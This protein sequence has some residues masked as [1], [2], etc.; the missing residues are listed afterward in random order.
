MMPLGGAGT[1]IRGFL[2]EAAVLCCLVSCARVAAQ[3]DSLKN[4]LVGI[5]TGRG[6]YFAKSDP[7]MRNLPRAKSC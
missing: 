5:G 7:R 6:A 4:G 1:T 3:G 2:I